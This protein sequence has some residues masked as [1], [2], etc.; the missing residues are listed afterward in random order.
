MYNICKYICIHDYVL[1]V[2]VCIHNYVLYVCVSI[3]DYVLY[4]CVL[5]GVIASDVLAWQIHV[6]ILNTFNSVLSVCSRGVV[7]SHVLTD[8]CITL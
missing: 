2:C 7:V 8:T 1:Y 6:Y 3:H 5:G 4:V